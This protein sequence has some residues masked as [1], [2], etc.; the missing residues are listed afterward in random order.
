MS[1]AL[2]PLHPDPLAT[3]LNCGIVAAWMLSPDDASLRKKFT[4]YGV[5]LEGLARLRAGQLAAE[6]YERFYLV[7]L[8]APS[9]EYVEAEQSGRA[10]RGRAAGLVVHNACIGIERRDSSP[11]KVAMRQA[12]ESVWGRKSSSSNHVHNAVW[13]TFRPVSALWASFVYH[14]DRDGTRD[15]FPCV[16]HD[17]PNFLAVAESFRELAERSTPP[18]RASTDTVLRVGES[19]RLPEPVKSLLP[20]GDLRIVDRENLGGGTIPI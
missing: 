1:A 4:Q 9:P 10:K 15:V 6:D 5:A 19:V 18:R 20:R 8:H 3:R 14:E 13:K 16:P 12:E 7:A 17:L 2:L 11:M